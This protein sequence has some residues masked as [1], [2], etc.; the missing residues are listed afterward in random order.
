VKVDIY[1]R[2]ERVIAIVRAKVLEVS[3]RQSPTVRWGSGRDNRYRT[4]RFP[5]W[6][7]FSPRKTN[8]I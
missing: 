2:D 6:L 1:T 7:E 5:G 3:A 4:S 8:L